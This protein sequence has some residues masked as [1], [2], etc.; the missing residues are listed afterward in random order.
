MKHSC[1]LLCLAASLSLAACTSAPPAPEEPLVP[2]P[3][4]ASAP[5]PAKAAEAAPAPAEKPASGKA[6]ASL[7]QG[8]HAYENGDYKTSQK[9]LQAALALGL[10]HRG[11][12]IRAHKYLAFIA[13]ASAQRDSCKSHFL[14]ILAM[15][16]RF[17]LTKAE[18]GHPVWGEVFREAKAES[19]KRGK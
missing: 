19:S 18:V 11:D 17:N 6:E 13:C 10:I 1:P 4:T 3:A 7:S 16:P 15:N 9:E 5:A 2:A 8:I 12:Q 14:R